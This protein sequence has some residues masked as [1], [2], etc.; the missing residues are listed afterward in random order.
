VP[1]L[2]LASGS[3][4]RLELIRR[5]V[6]AYRSI[7]SPVEET[8]STRAPD[9]TIPPLFLAPPFPVPAE[10]APRLWAWRKAADVIESNGDTIAPGSLVLGA[11]TVVVGP[12]RLLGK[13]R[14]REEAV[15]MLGLLRGIYHYVVTGFAILRTAEV[16]A[17]PETLLHQAVVSTV[18]MRD[19]SEFE[20]E[21]YVATDEPYDKAGAYAV[22]GMGGKLVSSVEGCMTNVIGLPVCA[23]RRAIA[24]CGG[25]VLP[26]PYGG[27]CEHCALVLP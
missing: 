11:D 12:G 9:F 23:V 18:F 6:P 20:L 5:I 13:P 26:Y 8:G 1:D 7:A 16:H 21:G 10:Q 24:S 4:R 14:S 25:E 22:Q 19:F 27:F 15:E 17:Q 2:I 3:P